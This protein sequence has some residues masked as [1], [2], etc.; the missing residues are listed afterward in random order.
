MTALPPV[1]ATRRATLGGL[2]ATVVAG[3]DVSPAPDEPAPAGSAP[4]SA[5]SDPDATLVESVVED[6]AGVLALVTGASRS[7]RSL[8]PRLSPWRR[9]HTA[10]LIALEAS[11]RSDASR[12]RGDAAALLARVR[13]EE[14]ALQRRLAEA[15]VA[16]RS[17]ALASL[18]ASMSAAVGQQLAPGESRPAGSPGSDR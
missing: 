12:P 8:R 9:L 3:C 10:H 2:V 6:V 17:G 15:A 1:R 14:T 4:P 13:R 18:L 5:R 7:R 16:A 11:P